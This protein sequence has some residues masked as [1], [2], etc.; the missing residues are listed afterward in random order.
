MT[1]KLLTAFDRYDELIHKH[2]TEPIENRN[3]PELETAAAELNKIAHEA[4]ERETAII[5]A[6]KVKLITA[7]GNVNRHAEDKDQNCARVNYGVAITAA[8]T[9]RLF[10]I[11]AN[12]PVLIEKETCGCS[13]F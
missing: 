13:R 6:L 3:D 8:E 1:K 4:Q 9:L 7:A 12:I 2:I 10:G 11:E 5:D